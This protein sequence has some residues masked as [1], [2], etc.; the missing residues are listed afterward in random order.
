MTRTPTNVRNVVSTLKA[1]AKFPDFT[2]DQE[3]IIHRIIDAFNEGD[4]PARDTQKINQAIK[5]EKNPVQLFKK[6][7]DIIDEKYLFGR[8]QA[9]NFSERQRQ[10]TLSCSL[11]GS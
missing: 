9:E 6:I 5:N 1:L 2:D 11:K 4:I 7:F 8:Q 3:E 10:V